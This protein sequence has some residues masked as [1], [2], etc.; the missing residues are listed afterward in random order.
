LRSLLPALAPAERRVGKVIVS[1]PG[2]SDETTFRSGAMASRIAALVVV[3]CLFVGVATRRW[4]PATE[5]ILRTN[6][7]ISSRR[8]SRRGRR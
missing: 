5:A 3:D 4:S 2:V 1:D 6:Q 7:A 8:Q